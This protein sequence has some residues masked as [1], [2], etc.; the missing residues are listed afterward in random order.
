MTMR[1]AVVRDPEILGGTLCFTGTRVPVRTLFDY[2]ESGKSVDFFL[3]G[4]SWV[5]RE[6]VI[7]VLEH[8]VTKLESEDFLKH[9]A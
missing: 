1:E 6:K 7:A 2:L 5:G 4:F 9:A 3:E 8:S